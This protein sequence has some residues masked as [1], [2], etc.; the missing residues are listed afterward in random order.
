MTIASFD[1]SLRTN[2][3]ALWAAVDLPV[4]DALGQSLIDAWSAPHRHY[5][6]LAHL[7]FVLDLIAAHRA[8][9]DDPEAVLLAAWFH[10]AV[11]APK[12][13]DN[14]ELS[15]QW[16]ERDLVACGIATTRAA[17]IGAMI[18]ATAGHAAARTRDEALLLDA[19]LAV[20][21]A[22][23]DVFDAYERGIRAEYAWAPW[24]L[25]RTKRAEVLASFVERPRIYATD[26]FGAAFEAAARANLTRSLTLLKQHWT[27]PFL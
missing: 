9:A 11:Y 4:P 18:R 2:W 3:R 14:E 8:L 5:H 13:S 6:T 22:D 24:L 25:Y 23:A 10:D 21:G 17:R 1:A 27:D 16:A 15:A 7:V 19:D 12:R 20:L 26:A